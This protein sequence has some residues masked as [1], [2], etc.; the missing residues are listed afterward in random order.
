MELFMIMM[1]YLVVRQHCVLN[2]LLL[3]RAISNR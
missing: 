2:Q 3:V 1:E